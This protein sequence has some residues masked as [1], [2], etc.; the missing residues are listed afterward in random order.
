MGGIIG[1]VI[2]GVGSMMAGQAQA[3]ASV[4]A[5]NIQAQAAEQ[6]SQNALTGYRYLTSG[7]GQQPMN[8]IVQAGQTAM[9]NQGGIQDSLMQLTGQEPVQAGTANAFNKYLGSTGYNF[10]LNQGTQAIGDSAAAKGLLDSGATA[11][12][13]TSYGQNM[14]ASAFQNYLSTLSGL[15]STLGQTSLNGQNALGQIASAGTAGGGASA[16]ALIQGAANQG[17]AIVGGGNA[18]ANGIAGAAGAFG[19]A[20]S[21]FAPGNSPGGN[22]FGNLF[23]M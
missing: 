20:L 4:Q 21:N 10:Q 19:N 3:Q 7:P 9:G 17:N 23:S 5:A 18:A 8:N 12:A 1:G 11:K 15:N 2:G 13:L 6:A 14:G 16:N 22:G